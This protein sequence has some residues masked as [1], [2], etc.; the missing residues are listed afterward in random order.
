MDIFE[1]IKPII[2]DKLNVQASEIKPESKLKDDL[3]S[4]S[5]DTVELILEC[6]RKF[7][8]NLPDS[9]IQNIVTIQDIVEVIN[10]KI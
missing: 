10:N 7:G 5:L 6:E 8:I 1:E 2:A 4:D 3:G 9:D